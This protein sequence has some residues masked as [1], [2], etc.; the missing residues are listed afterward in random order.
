MAEPSSRV[1][2][3]SDPE[4]KNQKEFKLKSGFAGRNLLV[5]ACLDE[6]G[7]IYDAFCPGYAASPT[8][9]RED[10]FR[11]T[12][13][14]HV[15][16]MQRKAVKRTFQ[17]SKRKLRRLGIKGVLPE[18]RIWSKDNLP[19]GNMT[20]PMKEV[21]TAEQLRTFREDHFSI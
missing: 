10:G 14:F 17:D 19:T 7:H 5:V 21:P 15:P 18:L 12:H 8:E 9:K 16:E 2:T 11:S 6:Q 1:Y 4:A 20:S 3:R 13:Y